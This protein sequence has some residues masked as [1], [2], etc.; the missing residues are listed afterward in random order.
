MIVGEPLHRVDS[1]EMVV[2][3]DGDDLAADSGVAE[4]PPGVPET[5][6]LR[7]LGTAALARRSSSSSVR[8]FSA[9]GAGSTPFIII[10]III[11]TIIIM[12]ITVGAACKRRLFAPLASGAQ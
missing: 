7:L 3:V 4:G 1:R 12:S 10:I 8:P 11:I 2:E 9:S 6:A 5:L